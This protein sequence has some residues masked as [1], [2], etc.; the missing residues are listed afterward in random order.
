MSITPEPL[1]L[2]TLTP[3]TEQ[4]QREHDDLTPLGARNSLI[5]R[6]GSG[7]TSIFSIT[8][9][10][11]QEKDQMARPNSPARYAVFVEE[12]EVRPQPTSQTAYRNLTPAGPLLAPTASP[13]GRQPTLPNVGMA[14]SSPSGYSYGSYGAAYRDPRDAYQPF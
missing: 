9:Y 12:E 11:K 6:P 7:Q 1:N 10:A 5:E 4:M 8:S 3:F 2:T 14:T 13:D